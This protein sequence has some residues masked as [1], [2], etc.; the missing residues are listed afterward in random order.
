MP[1]HFFS[2]EVDFTPSP[3]DPFKAWITTVIKN[4][5]FELN[6]LNFIFC[7]DSYLLNINREY[8][9]HDD[10][11]DIITFDNSEDNLEISGDIFISIE[12]V[13]ENAESIGS[14]FQEEISR[15]MIHGVLHLMGWGDKTKKEKEVIRKKEDDCLSLRA[16]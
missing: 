7:A 13:A 16:F 15:V 3:N 12:R 5:G 2:E 14:E 4:E 8:L 11:T 9:N 6:Q 10:Y 1:I